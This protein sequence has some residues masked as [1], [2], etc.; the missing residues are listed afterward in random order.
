VAAT[1]NDGSFWGTYMAHRGPYG[2]GSHPVNGWD[3]ST[4]NSARC[5]TADVHVFRAPSSFNTITT[6]NNTAQWAATYHEGGDA[7]DVSGDD[8][9][10]FATLGIAHPRCFLTVPTGANNSTNITCTGSPAVPANYPPASGWDGNPVIDKEGTK[11]IPDGLLTPGAHVEY[12]FRAESEGPPITTVICPDTT[13]VNPQTLEGSTDA[14][15]WQ[16]FG[17]LPDRWKNNLFSDPSGVNGTGMACMLYVDLNDRRGNERVWVSVSDSIGATAANKRGA[18]NGWTARGDQHYTD[19]LTG[20]ALCITCGD[21]TVGTPVAKHI[22]QPGSTW[23]M[24][25]VKASESLT[26]SAGALG[27]RAGVQATGLALGKDAKMGP[28]PDMLRTYYRAV[29]I[30]SGDLNSGVLGKFIN[31]GQN[32][33]VLLQD[34]LSISAPTGSTPR[35]IFVSGDGFVQ[36]EWATG[37]PFPEH[38]D[39]LTN[40]LGVSIKRD[41]GGVEQPSYQ[42]WSGNVNPY[43]DLI[44]AGPI[45]GDV[46]SVGNACLWGNDVLNVEV[47]ATGAVASGFYQNFGTHGPY[48]SGVYTPINNGAGKFYASYVDGF[49]I[50]HLFSRYGGS[51]LGRLGYYFKLLTNLQTSLGCT[52]VGTPAVTLDVP[53][54]ENGGQ[55][56]DFLQVRNNPLVTGQATVHFGLSRA[57]RVQVRVYDVTG[58]LVRTLADRTFRA[59][60][61]DLVWDGTDDAGR[62]MSRGVY[63]TQVRYAATKF[64]DAKK[65]TVLK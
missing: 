9:L 7:L 46:Y 27:N 1:N 45:A 20:T 32:D 8:A 22:G 54:N 44:T 2:A 47:N 55:F 57:D 52:L 24:Y 41:G 40:Y 14:H 5:D 16:Q 26:T 56:V 25:G 48:V 63:F 59:G 18:H 49:D 21:P 17:I 60:E 53:G 35:A 29:M 62:Q 28:T 11:I 3:I 38:R 6:Y 43:V 42:P 15:R 37:G 13:I 36:S 61:H 4:W 65:L 33:V 12:F 39:L 31:R 50:E 58:R 10:K 34:Y 23:D 19:P 64:T 51:S 30:L